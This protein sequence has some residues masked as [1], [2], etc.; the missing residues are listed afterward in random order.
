MSMRASIVKFQRLF[1][2]LKSAKTLPYRG[3]QLVNTQ[4]L[5]NKSG[6]T[7]TKSKANPTTTTKIDV[8]VPPLLLYQTASPSV[9]VSSAAIDL[10]AKAG[11]EI[12]P[13]SLF[14]ETQTETDTKTKTN[15]SKIPRSF[16][17]SKFKYVSPKDFHHELPNIPI[18]EIAF[19]GR[20]NVGKSSL[21]NALTHKHLARI[22]KTPGRTQQV[23]YFGLYPQKSKFVQE[24]KLKKHQIADGVMYQGE[25]VDEALGFIIDLPGYGYAKAPDDV[26]EQWQDNTQ[27]FLQQRIE[28]GNLQRVYVL[29][30]AR[31]GLSLFDTSILSWL[32]EAQCN[33][34][35]IL[36]KCDTVRR[37]QIIKF[38]NE[39]CYRY[40]SQALG[41]LEDAS[42]SPFVHVTSTKK[43]QG[44]LDLMWSIDADF[45]KGANDLRV[46]NTGKSSGWTSSSD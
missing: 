13:K 19:L 3:L 18:P 34:T 25:G 44:I 24:D 40:H 31:R 9:F 7:S 29:I 16:S 42:Q 2:S 46:L 38:A 27:D 37:P 28:V 35:I 4:P 39:I 14:T 30:D 22:S 8:E 12:H 32:D 43:K 1:G 26:V 21:L 15:K 36:T 41:T 20:S 10:S 5:R 23:N 6:G 17:S 11:H 45:S 33:Y